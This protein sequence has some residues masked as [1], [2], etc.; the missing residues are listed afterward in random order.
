MVLGDNWYG[1]IGNPRVILIDSLFHHKACGL[2]PMVCDD[3]ASHII[4][5]PFVECFID[6][7]KNT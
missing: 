1:D 5:T 2:K 4:A 7:C 3:D 6:G